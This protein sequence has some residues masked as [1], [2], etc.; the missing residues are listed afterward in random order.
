[1]ESGTVGGK[2]KKKGLTVETDQCFKANGRQVR[3]NNYLKNEK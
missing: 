3:G 2:C 1:M